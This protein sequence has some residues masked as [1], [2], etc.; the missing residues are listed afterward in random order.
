[1][2]SGTVPGYDQPNID[3][4][5]RVVFRR[6]SELASCTVSQR[7]L[8]PTAPQCNPTLHKE[9]AIPKEHRSNIFS[10]DLCRLKPFFH[11]RL[12][13]AIGNHYS[14]NG[15]QESNQRAECRETPPIGHPATTSPQSAICVDPNPGPHLLSP[16]LVG[17]E[18]LSRG[19]HSWQSAVRLC[20]G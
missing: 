9:T 8:R 3:R 15:Y 20:H 14:N 1:M 6:C 12:V 13:L 5:I 2:Y 18:C 17:M 4:M 10:L 16:F 11:L 7:H 19:G